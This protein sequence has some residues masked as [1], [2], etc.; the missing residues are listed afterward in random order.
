MLPVERTIV[1]HVLRE[2]TLVAIAA[3]ASVRDAVKLMTEKKIGAVLIVEER[4]LV[5]IF[6]ER[7]ALTRVLA[8]DREPNITP[9][10]AV[11]TPDPDSVT[12]W[13]SVR[14]ALEM[15]AE[16]GYRHLPVA[17]DRKVIGIVSIRDLYRSVHDQMESDIMLLAESLIQG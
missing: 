15:M 11:M 1:P 4:R 5:G 16:H 8:A 13:D 17:D 9:V 7:D 3:D 12:P 10:R 6:T 14:D 2:Q